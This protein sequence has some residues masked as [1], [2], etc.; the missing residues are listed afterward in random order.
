MPESYLL[1]AVTVPRFFSHP[2][3]LL[4]PSSRFF[5]PGSFIFVGFVCF[6]GEWL[7]TECGDG[8]ERGRSPPPAGMRG[9]QRD[10]FMGNGEDL[11]GFGWPWVD[12]DAG[13]MRRRPWGHFS[14]ALTSP[15]GHGQ[16]R[17]GILEDSG[18][19]KFSVYFRKNICFCGNFFAEKERILVNRE[20]IFGFLEIFIPLQL[21]GDSKSRR[22]SLKKQPA[23]AGEIPGRGK[24]FSA[25]P[26]VRS[27]DR[28]VEAVC[29]VPYPREAFG[30][31][32]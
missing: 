31:P 28:G 22:R 3:S 20:K 5:S 25:L 2:S 16:G 9:A 26:K 10:F 24:S 11:W 21:E 13:G 1:V 6:Y 14:A 4:S 30:R 32:E 18:P 23:E 7:R 17:A 15:E 27:G 8:A 29:G 12:M 19:A